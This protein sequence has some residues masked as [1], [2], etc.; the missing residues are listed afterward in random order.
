M[1]LNSDQMDQE[2]D[3]NR[4]YELLGVAKDATTEQIKAAFEKLEEEHKDSDEPDGVT[5]G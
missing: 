1:S 4:L 5:G 3:N 2:V